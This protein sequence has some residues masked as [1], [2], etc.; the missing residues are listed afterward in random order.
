VPQHKPLTLPQIEMSALIVCN[1][2]QTAV[3]NVSLRATLCTHN[4]RR[5]AHLLFKFARL[6]M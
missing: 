5:L 3:N 6:T 1:I 2:G 4:V